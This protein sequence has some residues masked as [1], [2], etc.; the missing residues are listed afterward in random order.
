[1]ILRITNNINI[2][3]PGNTFRP[4][5]TSGRDISKMPEG[6]RKPKAKSK[7]SN[8]NKAA[9]KQASKSFL[10]KFGP[11]IFAGVAAAV[12]HHLDDDE[13][14][15]EEAHDPKVRSVIDDRASD[16]TTDSE[17]RREVRHLKRALRRKERR[18]LQHGSDEVS[19][20]P[21]SL[22]SLKVNIPT[23][24]VQDHDN[25]H[26]TIPSPIRGLDQQ[27]SLERKTPQ[28]DYYQNPRDQFS[29]AEHSEVVEEDDDLV[30]SRDLDGLSIRPRH[31]HHH[32]RHHEHLV[33]STH[34]R[35][36]SVPVHLSLKDREEELRDKAVEAAKV[37]ALTGVIEALAISDRHGKWWE[38]GMGPKG[39]RTATAVAAGF[40]TAW[41]R[42]DNPDIADGW[43]TAANVGRG[44][45]ITRIVHGSSA[46]VDDQW[47]EDKRGRRRRRDSF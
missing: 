13:E 3:L 29:T 15:S 22:S 19:S 18:F 1:M 25:D 5:R 42:G 38:N 8:E 17:L 28:N 20:D 7:L 23:T 34:H 36:S 2:A 24:V 40:R 33:H 44:L 26:R 30:A 32:H 43:E 12:K 35:H 21:L 46:R 9:I 14:R 47:K 10:T 39:K 27:E 37:A 4:T 11:I 45:L 16:R 6:A 31:H 41:A